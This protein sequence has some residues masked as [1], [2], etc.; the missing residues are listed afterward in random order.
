MFLYSNIKKYTLLDPTS[1]QV[2]LLFLENQSSTEQIWA[3]VKER[4]QRKWNY[5]L[6]WSLLIGNE[7]EEK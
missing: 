3:K 7:S 4:K 6:I 2:R 1:I 5:R